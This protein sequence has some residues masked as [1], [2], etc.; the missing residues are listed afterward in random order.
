MKDIIELNSRSKYEH[1]YLKKMLKPDGGESKTYIL[2]L[3]DSFIRSG[4]VDGHKF[5]DPTGGPM[6]IEGS[7]LEEADAVVKSIDFVMGYGYTITFM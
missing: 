4:T 2:K 5:I 6:I 7:K 1:H 3:S